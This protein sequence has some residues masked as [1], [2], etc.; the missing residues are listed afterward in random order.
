MNQIVL[1]QHADAF[2]RFGLYR[3]GLAIVGNLANDIE[4]PTPI[5]PYRKANVF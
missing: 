5:I 3:L 4:L 2:I 1:I